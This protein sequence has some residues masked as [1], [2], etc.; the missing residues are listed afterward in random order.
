MQI[1][2]EGPSGNWGWFDFVLNEENLGLDLTKVNKVCGTDNPVVIDIDWSDDDELEGLLWYDGMGYTPVSN[3]FKQVKKFEYLD[4]SDL[5]KLAAYLRVH[6]GDVDYAVDHFEDVTYWTIS[7]GDPDPEAFARELISETGY[8][9]EL[10]AKYFDYEAFGRDLLLNGYDTDE[11]DEYT[12]GEEY[13]DDVYGDVE[14]YCKNVGADEA[15]NYFDYAAY[16]RTLA[17]TWDFDDVTCTWLSESKKT[18]KRAS[19]RIKESASCKTYTGKTWEE[20]INDVDTNSKFTVDSAYCDKYYPWII[21]YN[22]F[23]KEPYDAAVTKYSDGTYELCAYNIKPSFRVKESKIRKKSKGCKVK[24]S[25]TK[26]AIELVMNAAARV[27]TWDDLD[28]VLSSLLSL[29]KKLYLKYSEMYR[30][31]NVSPSYIG[32]EISDELYYI[33]QD[34]V[35]ESTKLHIDE[36]VS[37]DRLELIVDMADGVDTWED[38]ELVL[39]KL[40]EVD[41]KL[42]R[43]YGELFRVQKGTASE[44]GKELADELYYKINK[45][46]VGEDVNITISTGDEEPLV[47]SIPDTE[48]TTVCPECGLANCICGTEDSGEGRFLTFQDLDSFV[49][50]TEDDILDIDDDFSDVPIVV[51]SDEG[52]EDDFSDYNE[53]ALGYADDIAD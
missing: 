37:K 23:T 42:F 38:L 25:A 4:D 53:R 10:I 11:T 50:Y 26:N 33:L 41:K 14:E 47:L 20:F 21:V 8:D 36:F 5:H 44:I 34:D 18:N 31:R 22:K 28:P 39:N 49:D 48:D 6:G 35:T 9:E 46:I 19:R 15:I 52:D 13:I 40:F 30:T 29:D 43:K 2:L 24:E 45:D 7:D 16:G 1:C 32:S 27:S 3:L 51:V 12:V 17:L